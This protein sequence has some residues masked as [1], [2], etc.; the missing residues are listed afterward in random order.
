LKKGPT[1]LA[2]GRRRRRTASWGG[3]EIRRG[4]RTLL[5]FRFLSGG[6]RSDSS[7][8]SRDAFIRRIDDR[9]SLNGTRSFVGPVVL[10]MTKQPSVHVRV[11]GEG[12]DVLR[13]ME[14]IR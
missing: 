5:F 3:R 4:R 11:V 9:A 2:L 1:G 14:E 6:F 13:W 12:A 10:L 8:V 7:R